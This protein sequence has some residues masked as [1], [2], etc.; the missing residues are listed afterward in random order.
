MSSTV[1]DPP[2]PSATLLLVGPVFIGALFSWLFFGVS[3]VQLYIYHVGFPVDGFGTAALV[4]AVFTLDIFQTAAVTSLGWHMLCGGWGL[5]HNLRRPGW[6][7]AAV[8]AVDATTAIFVQSFYAWRI[9]RLK[10]WRVVPTLISLV[11][12]ASFVAAL[13]IAVVDTDEL[14]GFYTPAVFWLGGGALSDIMISITMVYVLYIARRGRRLLN[15]NRITNHFIRLF[16]ETG[17]AV[18]LVAIL[19]LVFFFNLKST[20][21]HLTFALVLGKVYSNSLMTSLNSRGRVRASFTVTANTHGTLSSLR[22]GSNSGPE[23]TDFITTQNDALTSEWSIEHE[24]DAFKVVELVFSV[25]VSTPDLLS[26]SLSP[27]APE[28]G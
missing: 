6:T 10:S 22:A 20:N 1:A 21:L 23:F 7:W 15:D 12:L 3:I 16:V 5:E 4:Y 8:C 25:T 18:S 11:S 13:Y 17:V 24:D 9:Y 26:P 27:P 2:V 28:F 14:P 19:Q